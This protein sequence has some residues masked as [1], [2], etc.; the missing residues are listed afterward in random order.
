MNSKIIYYSATGNTEIMANYIYGILEDLDHNVEINYVSDIDSVDD[1]DYI[2]LGSP[3]MGVEEIEE[4]EFR[5]FFESLDLMDKKV[6]LF[7]SYDWGDGEWLETWQEEVE[8]MG[9]E[10]LGAFKA[11]LEPDM[12]VLEEI[13]MSIKGLFT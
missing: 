8:S 1:Y 3:A 2:F 4:Y 9:G 7:G 6:V 13:G 11:E 10:V 12:D 5:P